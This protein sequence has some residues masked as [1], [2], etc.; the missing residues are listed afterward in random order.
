M[1]IMSAMH[2]AASRWLNT[3]CISLA[4]QRYLGYISECIYYYIYIAIIAIAIIY[5]HI[6]YAQ[7]SWQVVDVV[8]TET[9][10]KQEE[11]KLRWNVQGI[12]F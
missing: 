4:F 6:S 8:H 7:G 3:L 11:V 12:W 9:T 5:Y 10:W 2:K 1:N